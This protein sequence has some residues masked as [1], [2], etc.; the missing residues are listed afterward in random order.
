MRHMSP[1]RRAKQHHPD[2]ADTQE[3]ATPPVAETEVDE[4][5]PWENWWDDEGWDMR[6]EYY[7]E[8]GGEWVEDDPQS[9][10][11]EPARKEQWGKEG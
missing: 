1:P 10:V 2:E 11:G 8:Q 4:E 7:E 3:L 9:R 6:D 5:D